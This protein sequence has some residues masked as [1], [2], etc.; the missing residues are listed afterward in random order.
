MIVCSNCLKPVEAQLAAFCSE[1]C[2]DERLA[3]I[4][5]GQRTPCTVCG[6]P[7]LHPLVEAIWRGLIVVACS[8][9]CLAEL[10]VRIT[11]AVEASQKEETK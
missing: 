2:R 3:I 1:D 7:S 6:T 9:P 5:D 11:T 4:A 8:E 10:V